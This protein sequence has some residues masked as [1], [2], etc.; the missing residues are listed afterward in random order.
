M[1][2]SSLLVLFFLTVPRIVLGDIVGEAAPEFKMEDVDVNVVT[3]SSLSDKTLMLFHFNTYCHICRQ[4]V[5]TI[6]K[7][8]QNY[9]DRKHRG[10]KT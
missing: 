2:W 5:P 10:Q 8:Q 1:K 4:E 7:I 9:P 6:N 3:L